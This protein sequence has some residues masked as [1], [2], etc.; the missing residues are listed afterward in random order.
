M[1]T[2]LSTIKER[3]LQLSENLG[4]TKQEFFKKIEI[5]YGNFTGDKKK[6]PI[7]SNAIENI[8][9]IYP[10]TN[11]MWLI[12]GAGDMFNE[13][14]KKIE[15]PELK[16]KLDYIFPERSKELQ[17]LLN[18]DPT[19]YQIEK[20]IPLLPVDAVAGYFNSQDV[21]VMLHQ[22]ERFTL[23]ISEKVDFLVTVNGDSMHPTCNNGDI[24]ACVKLNSWPWFQYGRIYVIY[25]DQGLLIKRILK[26]V[27]DENIV[28]FSDNKDHYESFEIKIS[29][30]QG[31]AIV[32][33]GVWKD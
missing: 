3:I 25:T 33:G 5:T 14:S 6:T 31:L 28:L 18:E 7:N 19:E 24:V 13:A 9:R 10:E 12:T 2:K 11:L 16:K 22:C 15:Y 1:S 30:I 17:N 20:D 23:P 21:Q 32:V 27:N 4:V 26:S 8:L 29:D